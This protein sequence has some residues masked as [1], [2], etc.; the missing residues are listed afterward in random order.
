MTTLDDIV[1]ELVKKHDV[2]KIIRKAAADVYATLNPPKPIKR[3][4]V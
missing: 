4:K 3:R 2:E 1:R